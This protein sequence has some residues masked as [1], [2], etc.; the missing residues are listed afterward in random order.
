MSVLCA[1][2]GLAGQ[3]RKI[4]QMMKWTAKPKKSK[5]SKKEREMQ[6]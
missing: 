6:K 1:I 2:C 5:K 3:Q 4:G